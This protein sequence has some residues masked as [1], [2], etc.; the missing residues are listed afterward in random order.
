[1]SGDSIHILENNYN[2]MVLL[3]FNK[4]FSHFFLGIPVYNYSQSSRLTDGLSSSD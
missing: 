3:L 1:M 2:K 4:K